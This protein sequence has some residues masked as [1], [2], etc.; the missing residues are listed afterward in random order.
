M[1]KKT[2]VQIGREVLLDLFSPQLL[3][4]SQKLQYYTSKT[5]VQQ[6]SLKKPI[7]CIISTWNIPYCAFDHFHS[8]TF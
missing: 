3:Y 5:Q 4:T 6:F 7:I 2:R 1:L 8:W